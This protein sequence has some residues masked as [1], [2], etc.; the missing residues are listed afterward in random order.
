MTIKDVVENKDDIPDPIFFKWVA[1]FIGFSGLTGGAIANVIAL[2]LLIA[3]HNFWTIIPGLVVGFFLGG[4]F[5]SWLADKG[6]KRWFHTDMG[7][8][9]S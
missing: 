9:E 4:G 2:P 5:G 7:Q 1:L 3:T 8:W 6:M